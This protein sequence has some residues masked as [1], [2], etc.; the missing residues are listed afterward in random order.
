MDIEIRI[1]N[2]SD[3]DFDAVRV[4]FPD[5]DVA[6]F[7]P[8]S[9]GT[10]SGFKRTSRAY[11]YAEIHASAGGREFRLQPFDYVGERKLAP[12][13]HT[14]VLGVQ[15]GRLTVELETAA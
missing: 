8:V 7:G 15:E 2:A 10:S 5:R 12:G 9:K 4:V 14:Y 3:I 6:E 11:R 13:R 1:R